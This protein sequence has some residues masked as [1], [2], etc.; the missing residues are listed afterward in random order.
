MRRR[1]PL[2]LLVCVLLGLTILLITIVAPSTVSAQASVPT[3][4]F[5]AYDI[6]L[7]SSSTGEPGGTLA[8][9]VHVPR[10]G[11]TRYADGAP[12]IIMVPGGFEPGGIH[13][14]LSDAADGIIGITFLLPGGS[15]PYSGLSS[16]GVYDYRGERCIAALRD[17]VLYAAGV[18]GDSE[19]RTL[20]EVVPVPVLH[21]NVGIIGLSN[22]GNLPVAAAALHGEVLAPYLRY[23]IQW[24]TPVSSQIATRDL[25]RI[26]L[27]PSNVQADYENPFG[28]GYGPWTLPMDYAQLTF[29]P[30]QAAYPILHD[31]SG[32]SRYTTVYHPHLDAQVP[33]VNLDG[34]IDRD[35]DFPL[36]TCPVDAV[37]VTYSR[38]VMR[39]IVARGLFG[40][41]WPD[42]LVSL[43]EAEAYWDLRESVV[44]YADAVAANP[45]LEAMLLCGVRDHVQAPMDKPHIHQAF[46]G[47]A[48]HDAW[49]KINPAPEAI[50]HVDPTLRRLPLVDLPANAPPS[51]WSDPTGYALPPAVPQPVYQ[52][53]AIYEMADR[54]HAATTRATGNPESQLITWLDTDPRVGGWITHVES[55]GLGRIAVHIR[56]PRTPRYQEGAPVII[57]V[58]GFFTAPP[59]FSHQ[60]DPDAIGAVYVTYLWPG[61]TDRRTGAYSEGIFDYGGADCLR[62]LRDIIRFAVGDMA[63]IEGRTMDEILDLPVLYDV[64]GLYAFSHSGIAATNV[65][66][67]HGDELS[68]VR[69]F[70]GRE[71]PT[72]DAMYPLEPGHWDDET[73]QAVHNPF[74]DPSGYT[75]TSIA[76][77]YSTVYWL[78]NDD[79]PEGRP[80]FRSLDP[81]TPD[82][83]CSSK[84]P[85]MWDKDYWSTGLLQALLDNGSL[86]R[87]SWPE[88]LATPEEAASLWP[89]RSTVHRYPMLRRVLPNLK[90]MLVFAAEDHVQTALDKPHIRQAYDGFHKAA[91]LWCRLNPDRAYVLALLASLPS[92]VIPD[93][94]ANREPAIW[95]AIRSW[96]YPP[97]PAANLNVFVPLA[98]VAEMCDRT[99]FDRWEANLETVLH[100]LSLGGYRP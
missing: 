78:Q 17:V 4:P 49:V 97:L 48:M 73:G 2:R 38:P 29:D 12:V 39:E 1:A 24:E 47:W 83:V 79:V 76:I 35:E 3:S 74:Y 77:D 60:L 25:G 84:H 42:D 58:S 95:G 59:G 5:D 51:D 82:Y 32:D 72:T 53:A 88:T 93:N 18:L 65:L 92:H 15:D 80:A 87:Q 14:G 69:F 19:G 40:D 28:T 98:A 64:V 62:A 21:R 94:P 44:L 31:G 61:Q 100:T 20:G 11:V 67:L 8:V 96:G 71:N 50:G 23:I 91:Q 22:G 99:Y 57:N 26:R 81:A 37:R 54:A 63:N 13:L 45:A 9:R 10:S 56:A 16:A 52:L 36:D 27:V 46:D 34:T 89:F 33:D 30:T 90:V 41:R 6:R 7:P 43:E 86:T 70:V 68:G 55:E 85:R 75:P 66:A